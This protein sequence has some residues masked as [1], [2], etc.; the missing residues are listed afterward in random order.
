MGGIACVGH[1]PR[2]PHKRELLAWLQRDQ[3]TAGAEGAEALRP[4]SPD[5]LMDGGTESREEGAAR[6][7]GRSGVSGPYSSTAPPGPCQLPQPWGSPASLQGL[8]VFLE[9][10]QEP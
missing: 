3:P 6:D 5:A 10:L 9:K 4:F 8:H 7:V 1:A 2:C